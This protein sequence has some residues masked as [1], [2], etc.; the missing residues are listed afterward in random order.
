MNILI[1]SSDSRIY[2]YPLH[3][4]D[5]WEVVFVT[6]GNGYYQMNDV[7]Y[8][9][10][11]GTA[12]LMP[13]GTFHHMISGDCV[14]I[15]ILGDF[16]H[17]LMFAE[18]MVVSDNKHEDGA[19]LVRMIYRNRYNNSHYVEDLC[20]T[21]FQCLLQEIGLKNAS[22]NAVHKICEQILANAFDS[23]I[24]VGNH[25]RGSG[26]AEDYIR[27]LFKQ[28]VGMTPLAF[29]TKIRIDHACLLLEMYKKQIPLTQIAEQC[30]YTDYIY[31]SKKFKKMMGV[32]PQKYIE[33]SQGRSVPGTE[34]V[35]DGE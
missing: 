17:F 7:T 10:C 27:M 5:C 25:L 29:L 6:E 32:S 21:Y 1:G 3:S 34:H 4:H 2:K 14:S 30:G 24:D 26:Y 8:P 19:R 22:D 9:F 20:K 16:G 13:P 12:F 28:K 11:P 18:P 23:N 15:Y 33:S 31:F 35:R